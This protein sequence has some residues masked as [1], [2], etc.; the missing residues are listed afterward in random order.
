MGDVLHAQDSNC[1]KVNSC[2]AFKN[3]LSEPRIDHG[4]A[5]SILHVFKTTNAQEMKQTLQPSMKVVEE[6]GSDA[7]KQQLKLFQ[8]LLTMLENPLSSTFQVLY[9]H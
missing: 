2:I 5:S 3:G 9:L 6:K 8:E 7:A 1:K 4:H